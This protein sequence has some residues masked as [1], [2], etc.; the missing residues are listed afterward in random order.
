VDCLVGYAIISAGMTKPINDIDLSRWREYD[1]ILTDSLWLLGRRDNSG[2]HTPQYWGNF[3]PQIPRQAMLRFTRA[4]E[5]VIDPFAGLGTTLIEA[6][7]L[8]RHCIGV[9]LNPTVAEQARQRIQQEP[10]TS[11]KWE[12]LVGDSRA[13]ETACA[14]AEQLRRWGFDHAQLLMLHPPYHDII[15]FSDDPRD[16]SNLPTTE[17]FCDGFEQVVAN[18]APLLEP[19]RF[20]VLVIGDQYR[21]KEWVPL[22]F[23]AME[24]VRK[25]GFRLKS[26]C[27]KDM[28]ENRGKRGQQHLWRYRALRDNYY[29]FKHEY[30]MFFEKR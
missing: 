11:V 10:A 2:A 1:A 23:Y 18:F 28:Q 7:R 29:V 13:P 4:G 16:L 8:G 20:L 3:V 17:Q 9:E 5:M 22:G 25:H 14:V 30:V 26:I 27:V 24:R 19:K 12:L 6:Q 21:R 15:R